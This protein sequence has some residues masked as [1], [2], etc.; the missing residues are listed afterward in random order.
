MMV[1]GNLRHIPLQKGFGLL[2]V[3]I[4]IVV[5]GVSMIAL[6]KLQ[7]VLLHGGSYA[8]A[9]SA[10][11]N[12]AQSKLEDLHSFTQLT[13]AGSGV[14]AYEEIKSSTQAESVTLPGDNVT[15]N[16]TWTVE[17]FYYCPQTSNPSNIVLM[18]DTN[19]TDGINCD[20]PYNTLYPDF[21]VVTV[22]VTWPSTDPENKLKNK[23]KLQSAISATDP[24]EEIRALISPASAS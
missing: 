7:V 22:T 1:M 15:Y 23:V 10:A 11:L 18:K 16:R 14:F 21:K 24:A 17:Y 20:A 12:L 3:L 9:R 8:R 4:T 6:A 5:L 13:G 2:E 19:L